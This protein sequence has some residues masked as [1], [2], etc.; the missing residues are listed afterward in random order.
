MKRFLF[1]PLQLRGN[2]RVG[3]AL[4]SLFEGRLKSPLPHTTEATLFSLFIICLVL[5][6]VANAMPAFEERQKTEG[7][8]DIQDLIQID[9]GCGSPRA[10]HRK[11]EG[12]QHHHDAIG[13]P[14]E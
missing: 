9:W 8:M 10:Y 14:F 13:V 4:A 2:S 6:G 5:G 11:P 1:I 7:F 3:E 12:S